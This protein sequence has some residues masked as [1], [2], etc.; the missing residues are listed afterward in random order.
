MKLLKHKSECDFED[1][2]VHDN[3]NRI[4][5]PLASTLRKSESNHASSIVTQSTHLMC[6]SDAKYTSRP[7]LGSVTTL[8]KRHTQLRKDN[9]ISATEVSSTSAHIEVLKK[10]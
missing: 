2:K 4:P 1:L 10:I 3:H 5:K 9:R 7:E 8:L 6:F